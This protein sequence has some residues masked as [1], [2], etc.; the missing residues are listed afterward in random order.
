MSILAGLSGPCSWRVE[1]P[2]NCLAS[3]CTSKAA[4][5]EPSTLQYPDKFHAAVEFVNTKPEGSKKLSDETSLVLHAL[6]QQATVGPA[7]P[8]P[9]SWGFGSLETTKWQAHSQLGDM[10]SVEA[11][12]LY[13]KVLEDEQADW[14]PLLG[15]A[16]Q[17][18]ASQQ[19]ASA[20]NAEATTALNVSAAPPLPSGGAPSLEPGWEAVIT[21]GAPRPAPRYEHAVAIVCGHFYVVGGN[22]GGRYL[23]DV[24][25]L[26]LQTFLWTCLQTRDK[27]RGGIIPSEPLGEDELEAKPPENA[28]SA[29]AIPIFPPCAGHR[30]VVWGRSLLC[31]GGHHKVKKKDADMS[32]RSLDTGVNMWSEVQTSGDHPPARGGH[33]ATLIGNSVY[34]FGGEDVSRRPHGDLYVLDLPDLSWKK[35]EAGGTPPAPRSAHVAT[36]F[37]KRYLLIFGGGSVAHCYNDL[38]LLDT[39][40]M[41]WSQPKTEGNPPSP[42]AGH[43]LPNAVHMSQ[44]RSQLTSDRV[45]EEFTSLQIETFFSPN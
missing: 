12:R 39:E 29:P 32:L 25:S 36:E 16:W 20:G 38:Y 18:K 10:A 21:N 14:A 31:I 30:I 28:A 33:T 43:A 42:R 4:A 7:G 41:Q 22:Y 11:M 9:R 5:A 35:V 23:N 44:M 6:Q 27:L 37:N 17:Q 15:K 40:T 2:R 26:N 1:L 24:W 45:R 13:V 3:R 8:R 19:E 34:V